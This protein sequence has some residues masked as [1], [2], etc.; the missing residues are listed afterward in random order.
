MRDR[1]R[2]RLRGSFLRYSVK[3]RFVIKLFMGSLLLHFM[4]E[5]FSPLEILLLEILLLEVLLFEISLLE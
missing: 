2:S 4:I 1:L 5:D 3:F